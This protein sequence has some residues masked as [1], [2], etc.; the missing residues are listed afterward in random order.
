MMFEDHEDESQSKVS[1]MSAKAQEMGSKAQEKAE[2]GK[3]KVADGIEGAV[4]TMR[5]KMPSDGMVG[6]AGTKAADGLERTAGYLRDHETTELWSD[7]Q[8]YVKLHPATSLVGAVAA[9]FVLSRIL[10]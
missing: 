2:V 10:R 1:E 5:E 9:G 7:V 4:G 8:E 3:D 6:K